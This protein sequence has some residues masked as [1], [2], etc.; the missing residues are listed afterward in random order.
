MI[1]MKSGDF[2]LGSRTRDSANRRLAINHLATGGGMYQ[3]GGV[4][5]ITP[6]SWSG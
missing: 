2:Y 3:I 4:Y 1:V 6:L 5:Q